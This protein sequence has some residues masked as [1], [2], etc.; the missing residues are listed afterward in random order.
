MHIPLE[1]VLKVCVRT[2][3]GCLK[4][5]RSTLAEMTRNDLN[6][7][8]VHGPCFNAPIILFSDLEMKLL[9]RRNKICV[10][11]LSPWFSSSLSELFLFI[12]SQLSSYFTQINTVDLFKTSL[13]ESFPQVLVF[14]ALGKLVQ[15]KLSPKI[16]RSIVKLKLKVVSGLSIELCCLSKH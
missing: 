3:W 16:L 10:T 14:I 12:F 5:A 7:L 8:H 11:F 6:V 2:F 1:A 9:M 13:E 15:Y 4:A